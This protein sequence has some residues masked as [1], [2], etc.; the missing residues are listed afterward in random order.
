MHTLCDCYICLCWI[1]IH[2]AAFFTTYCGWEINTVVQITKPE[3][4]GEPMR[5]V[6]RIELLIS[7]VQKSQDVGVV[8]IASAKI[9]NI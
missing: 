4:V 5:D 9:S 3:E 8:L 2:Q 1:S 7:E 6:K